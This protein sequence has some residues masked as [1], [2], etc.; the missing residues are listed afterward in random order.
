MAAMAVGERLELER[1]SEELE[2]DAEMMGYLDRSSLRPG[3]NV[4]LIAKDPH[5]ALTVAVDGAPV[6]VGAFAADRLFV[7][8][9]AAEL[10]RLAETEVG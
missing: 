2:L 8:L 1:I 5:G 6:G 3:A 4:E 9:G 10:L 7:A